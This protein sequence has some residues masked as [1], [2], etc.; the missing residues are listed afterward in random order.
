MQGYSFFFMRSVDAILF[1]P[2]RTKGKN[3]SSKRETFFPEITSIFSK[4]STYPI[5]ITE[6]SEQMVESLLLCCM[7]DHQPL[8]QLT[9]LVKKTLQSEKFTL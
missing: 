3:L 9:I 7:I 8:L 2:L 1:Q 6:D 4:L 5:S